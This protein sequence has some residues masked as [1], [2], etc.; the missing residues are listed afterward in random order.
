METRA[1]L[2]EYAHKEIDSP[3][4]PGVSYIAGTGFYRVPEKDSP[5]ALA[6]EKYSQNAK[7]KGT[8]PDRPHQ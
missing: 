6:L 5:Q 7:A 4:E 3:G 2:K 8:W 1:F